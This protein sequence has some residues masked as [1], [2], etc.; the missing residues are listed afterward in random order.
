MRPI[1]IPPDIHLNRY[2][3]WYKC[4]V[5]AWLMSAYRETKDGHAN[6]TVPHNW[7]LRSLP[8][9][10][11]AALFASRFRSSGLA[12]IDQLFERQYHHP[13]HSICLNPFYTAFRSMFDLMEKMFFRKQKKKKV[14]KSLM[15]IQVGSN[16]KNRWFITFLLLFYFILFSFCFVLYVALLLARMCCIVWVCN[17]Y[18][19]EI[20]WH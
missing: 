18:P 15:A 20:H 8:L 5:V 6:I 2:K 7:T 14:R 3:S 13:L 1:K 19:N 4:L 17:L 12:W 16:A 10:L 11:S 9:S